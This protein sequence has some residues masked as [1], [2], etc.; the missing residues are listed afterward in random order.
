MLNLIPP[1]MSETSRILGFGCMNGKEWLMIFSSG[2]RYAGASIHYCI[3]LVNI[4]WAVL[5]RIIAA[6]HSGV[7]HLSG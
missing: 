2:G 4:S 7:G 5:I 6:A 1:N 3:F